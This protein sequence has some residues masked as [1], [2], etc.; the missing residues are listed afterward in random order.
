M[1]IKKLIAEIHRKKSF[2]C[3]GLDT[4]MDKIPPFL[5]KEADPIFAFNKAIIDATHHLCVAYKPNTAFYEAYGIKGWKSFEKTISYLNKNYPEIFTIADAKRGDIGNTSRMY[6]K[7]FFQDLGFDSVTVAPYMGKDSVEPF[8]KFDN[9][10]TI[11]LALTSNQGAFDF[12][13]KLLTDKA[14]YQHVLE[15]SKSWVNSQN[16]MYVFG[17][18]KAEFLVKVRDIMPDN[19][20]LVPGVGAQGGNLKDISKYGMNDNVGLLVNSSRAIIY[21]SADEDFAQMAANSASKLQ[22][23]M[24][25][26]LFQ[27]FTS[28]KN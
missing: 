25:K 17:A 3:I 20:L 24:K 11:L 19:F 21:A 7:V 10:H 23:E 5:L 15:V 18:T 9:K 13:T 2:L 8:L 16:L 27:K 4:D 26:L 22:K 28:L 1:T 6:A 14:L 12:Q